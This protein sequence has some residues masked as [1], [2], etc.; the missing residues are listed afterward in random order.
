[1]RMRAYHTSKPQ[2]P[3]TAHYFLPASVDPA[4]LD[5]RAGHDR[6]DGLAQAQVSVGDDELHPGQSTGF[7]RAQERG[8][9]GAVL[10]V[11]DGEAEDLAAAIPAHPG[12]HHDRLGD[13][14]AV[15]PG[16]AV[17]SVHEHI[18]E[19]LAGQRAVPERRDLLVKVGTD[20]A[21]LALAEATVSPRARTRSST[22]LVLTP[23]R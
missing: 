9:E 1:M 4:A 16:L 7:Q 20:A 17:G 8:P 18:R 19:L 2:R 22:F 23:C 10:A 21:D 5:G 6:L 11:A 13:D 15:D 3:K 14:S 12:G